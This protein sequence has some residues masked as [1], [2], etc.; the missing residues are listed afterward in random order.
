MQVNNTESDDEQTKELHSSEI[1]ERSMMILDVTARSGGTT[2][3][4]ELLVE[5]ISPENGAPIKDQ[6]EQTSNIL[7]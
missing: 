2:E 6:N 4:S 5:N 1:Q 7:H 3:S